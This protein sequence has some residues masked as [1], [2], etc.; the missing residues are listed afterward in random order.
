ML[1]FFSTFGGGDLLYLSLSLSHPL[2]SRGGGGGQTGIEEGIYGTL[3]IMGEIQTLCEETRGWFAKGPFVES[4]LREV[5]LFLLGIVPFFFFL[6]FFIFSE[7]CR[8]KKN[9]FLA[10]KQ[11]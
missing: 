10:P 9:S 1:F 8:N 6:I 4:P 3:Q 11:N 2:P 5:R 7:M